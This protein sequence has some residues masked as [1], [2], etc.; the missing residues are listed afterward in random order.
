LIN[1]ANADMVGHTG[2]LKST[3]AAVEAVDECLGKLIPEILK[4]DGQIFI[5][6]DH[7]NAE[8]T[9]N[10]RTEEIDTEHSTFPVPLWYL[11]PK[12]QRQ[13]NESEI[14]RSKSSVGGLLSDVAPTILRAMD[15]PIPPEMTG[16][17]LLE[18]LK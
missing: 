11:N 3:I 13:K 18:I 15:L 7:G 1:F 2:N 4:M 14:I 12:N 6:A 8:E 17:D 10:P 16:Q 9:I 5:T